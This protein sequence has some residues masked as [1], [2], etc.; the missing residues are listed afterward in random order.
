MEENRQELME[1]LEETRPDIDFEN[2]TALIDKEMLDSFDIISIV[3]E[4][5]EAFDIS[6]NVN[7]LLPENFNSVD[8]ILALIA[9]L[10][11]E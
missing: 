3:S 1:I 10:Q 9:K 4:I 2:E 7:D 8:A 11:E 6:I 5:N